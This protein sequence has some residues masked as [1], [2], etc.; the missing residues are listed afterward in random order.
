MSQN[1]PK[2]VPPRTLTPATTSQ[3]NDLIDDE[4]DLSFENDSLAS[5]SNGSEPDDMVAE[6]QRQSNPLIRVETT[7]SERGGLVL[8][9]KGYK[10]VFNSYRSFNGVQDLSSQ[11][12]TCSERNKG[13]LTK[14]Q[15]HKK[16]EKD[17]L[18]GLNH[19]QEPRNKI[20]CHGRIWVQKMNDV[21]FV[22]SEI[23]DHS[24]A[25]DLTNLPISKVGHM[26]V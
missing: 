9:H 4:S 15:Q 6:E 3:N 21:Y 25:S 18:K 20:G 7:K 11:I 17:R 19:I 16:A 26:C 24:H 10:Y 5:N 22:E 23:R 1:R 8:H 12:W 14:N 13:Y 2:F